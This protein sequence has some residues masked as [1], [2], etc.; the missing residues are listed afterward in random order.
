MTVYLGRDRR[1][2]AQYLTATHTTLSELTKKIQGRGHKLYMDNYF[3][4]PDLFCDLATKQIC[5]CGT[6]WPNRKGTPQDLAPKRMTL[7]QGD[8]QVR[9]RGDLTAI[10]W[11]DRCDIRVL[12]NI[13][14]PPAEGNF[15]DCNGK[16]IKP[17]IVVDYNRHMG[18]VG[19]GDRMAET[20]SI[21]CCTWKWTKKLFFHLFDLAILNRYILFSSLGG[22]KI[23]L[24]DF[25][26]MLMRNL[27]AQAGQDQNVRRPVG[28][29]APAASTQ[30]IRFEELGRQHWPILSA[31]RRRCHMCAARGVT[32]KVKMI[33]RRCGVAL[34]CNSACFRDY[35]N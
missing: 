26:M 9:T 15:C 25:W 33:C 27:V 12:T 10:L 34:C 32:R 6:V 1:H 13:H 5:C 23:S 2:T 21:N 17:Q 35:R 22:K 11:R 8:L 20:Y 31:M 16:A 4:S 24:R 30:S 19:K 28:G 14:D 7:Q 3:S 18:Y 29:P